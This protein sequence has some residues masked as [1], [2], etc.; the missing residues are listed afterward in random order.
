MDEPKINGRVSG[1]YRFFTVLFL[2]KKRQIVQA[3][4][5]RASARVPRPR[6]GKPY[7]DLKPRTENIA[8]L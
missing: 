7:F 1:F 3:T 4:I 6:C 8:I 5:A 2:L